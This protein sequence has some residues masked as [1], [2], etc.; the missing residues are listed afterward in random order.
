MALSGFEPLEL[1]N[2]I[3]MKRIN[4]RNNRN[5]AGFWFAQ[6]DWLIQTYLVK[7]LVFFFPPCPPPILT[8]AFIVGWN[9]QTWQNQL[10]SQTTQ[11]HMG[12]DEDFRLK[13]ASFEFN[14]TFQG[15]C[16]QAVLPMTWISVFFLYYHTHNRL[17]INAAGMRMLT[18]QFGTLWYYGLW[19]S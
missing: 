1:I 17:T 8:S 15:G 2:V 14:V 16:P 7:C 13:M 18:L 6:S 5:T 19:S 3:H 12:L 10:E 11:L 4:N 9:I